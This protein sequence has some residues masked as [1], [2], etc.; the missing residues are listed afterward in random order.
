MA[1]LWSMCALVA[2]GLTLLVACG[3]SGGS[4]EKPGSTGAASTTEASTTEAPATEA[5]TAAGETFDP[6]D[7]LFGLSEMPAGWVKDQNDDDDDALCGTHLFAS[8][9]ADA[10]VSYSQQGELPQ[11]AERAGAFA[12]GG[13]AKALAATK[14]KYD[15]CSGERRNGFEWTVSPV[16]FPSLGEESYAY[17]AT[18][19]ADDLRIGALFTVMRS[20]DGVVGVVY[21]ELGEVNTSVA[22]DYARR[23]I[24][25]LEAA[26]S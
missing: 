16:S 23:A 17:L 5:P 24:A 18:A 3:G 9:R 21:A 13:A 10:E 1:R 19:E 20:G 4:A 7:V 11:V 12:P 2:A 15:G 25:R 26:Q 22:E 8:A 14:K 6:E